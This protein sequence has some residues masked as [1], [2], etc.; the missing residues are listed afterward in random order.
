MKSWSIFAHSFG[1]V[2]RNF[3]QAL[4]IGVVP[5]LLTF[6][7]VFALLSLLGVSLSSFLNDEEA[8]D[9]LV[10]TN[11]GALFLGLPWG[12]VDHCDHD[13]VDRCFLAPVCPA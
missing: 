12:L 5:V 13:A 2:F 1:M 11:S 9:L 7:V 6:A 8:M 3:R 10:Q 4:Q